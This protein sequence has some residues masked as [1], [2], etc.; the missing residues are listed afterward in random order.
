M[1][2]EPQVILTEDDQEDADA[3]QERKD[4]V[5]GKI[6]PIKLLWKIVRTGSCRISKLKLSIAATRYIERAMLHGVYGVP[7]GNVNMH[8]VSLMLSRLILNVCLKGRLE[9]FV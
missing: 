1:Q 6:Q 9:H 8:R 3:Y 7:N 2:I 4:R 5:T